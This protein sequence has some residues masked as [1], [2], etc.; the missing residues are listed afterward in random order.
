MSEAIREIIV[1]SN[2]LE[3]WFLN[4]GMESN[5]YNKISQIIP[6]WIESMV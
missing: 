1:I 6:I 4:I 5:I 2:Y 3:A